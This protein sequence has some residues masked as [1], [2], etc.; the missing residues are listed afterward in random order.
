[1][2]DIEKLKEPFPPECVE[3]RIGK[4]TKDKSKGMALAYIDARAV[5]D[6]LDE[7]CGSLNWQCRYTCSDQSSITYGPAGKNP[8]EYADKII[9]SETNGKTVCEI[10]IS[11]GQ[12]WVW[13]ADGAGDTDFEAEK[14]ALSD[15]FKRAAVKW[16]IGR[17]LYEVES[18]WVAID[19]WGNI[20]DVELEKLA[21]KL[22]NASPGITVNGLNGLSKEPAK[23]WTRKSLVIGLTNSMTT[24]VVENKNVWPKDVQEWWK[25][26]FRQG[27]DKAPTIDDLARYQTDNQ[28]ILDSLPATITQ[29]LCEACSIRAEQFSQIG[30]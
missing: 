20:L 13:K 10:G 16:G 30:A 5:M 27:I 12:E 25:E 2:I 17:Y 11:N 26:K 22:P 29:E 3:W 1:M 15:S 21:S 6:R 24:K 7:V 28:H 18:H 14:G 19:Q 9:I 4:K 23:F 8:K